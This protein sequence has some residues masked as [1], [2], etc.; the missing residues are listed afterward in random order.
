MDKIVL[1][2][3]YKIIWSIKI[4]PF[5]T[6]DEEFMQLAHCNI[7]VQKLRSKNNSKQLEEGQSFVSFQRNSHGKNLY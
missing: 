4:W 3:Q 1:K 5:A 7:R 6:L 2:F